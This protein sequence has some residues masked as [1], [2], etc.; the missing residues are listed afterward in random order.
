MANERNRTTFV[1]C[2]LAIKEV[3]SNDRPDISLDELADL[4]VIYGTRAE[5][6]K[7]EALSMLQKSLLEI[8]REG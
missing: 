4:A 3:I 6:T 1:S 2:R 7:E 5:T 8:C